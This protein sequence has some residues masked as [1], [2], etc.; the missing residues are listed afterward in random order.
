M[1]CYLYPGPMRSSKSGTPSFELLLEVL[2]AK[3]TLICRWNVHRVGQHRTRLD[4]FAPVA[5]QRKQLG[6]FL[7]I[8]LRQVLLLANVIS[9]IKQL[10]GPAF[11]VLEQLV[12]AQAN[13][14]AR[15]LHAVI[16]IMW[17]MPE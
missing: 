6:S 1:F 14:P 3:A 16:A 10:D 5:Q 15:T 11:K 4:V 9:Q 2:N 7:R 13:G 8:P 17:K 12:I